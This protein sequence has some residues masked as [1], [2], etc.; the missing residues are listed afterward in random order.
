ML[1]LMEGLRVHHFQIV[2][3][4]REV[5]SFGPQPGAQLRGALYNALSRQFCSETGYEHTPGHQTRCPV[6]WLLA[7]E[8]P[9]GE[10]GRDL[11]RP[12][13]IEPPLKP[14]VIKA[15]EIIAFGISLVG[16]R[17]FETLPFL[18][19][20]VESAGHDGVGIGRGRFSVRAIQVCNPMTGKRVELLNDRT[21]VNP[22][23]LP[24]MTTQIEEC[25]ANVLTTDRVRLRFL[26]PLR[27]GENKH[28]AHRPAMG[29]LLRRLVER[30]QA[31]V[32]HYGAGDQPKGR[33]TWRAL[34][35]QLGAVGDGAVL[36]EDKTRWLDVHS[37][38]RRR[39]TTSPIG[40]LLGEA[41]WEGDLKEAIP[42]L[43]W[44]EILHVGKSAVKGNGWF[45]VERT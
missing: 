33:Q 42:W 16:N 39:G 22:P 4:A 40:G 27:I 31:M 14:G 36:T 7:T 15:D 29:I 26:T 24:V 12:L 38:S 21:L 17:A 30:C 10:R 35:Q 20:A 32:E 2:L 23:N 41:T 3:R 37:G 18:I 44:G 11:P 34:Q 9:S 28:L 45:V 5:V 25:A 8:D 43:L 6:C 1:E 13:I 19:R